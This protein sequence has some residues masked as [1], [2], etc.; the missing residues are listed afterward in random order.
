LSLERIWKKIS[1]GKTPVTTGIFIRCRRTDPVSKG[2]YRGRRHRSPRRLPTE[3]AI[4]TT[5]PSAHRQLCRRQPSVE[6]S[7][8]QSPHMCRGRP[9][10]QS[11]AVGIVSTWWGHRHRRDGG[12]TALTRVDGTAV[13]TVHVSVPTAVPSVQL[14]RQFLP[15]PAMISRHFSRAYSLPPSIPAG[16]APRRPIYSHVFSSNTT[17]STF[18]LQHHRQHF[19]PLAPTT[20]SSELCC[21]LRWLHA[22]LH[23]FS[24]FVFFFFI[25]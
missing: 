21:L 14:S 2:K 13:G 20:G 6:L 9:S 1:S 18:L 7:R 12:E 15:L 22:Q 16:S 8:R 23:T 24:F 5:S 17:S 3:S 10:A 19:S 11:L 25:S 4:S